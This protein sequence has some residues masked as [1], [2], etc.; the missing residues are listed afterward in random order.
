M[1]IFLITSLHEVVLY[2]KSVCLSACL[3]A[4]SRKS[5]LSDFRDILPH[6]SVEK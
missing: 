5:Y 3:L 1:T 2:P 4:T 6:V